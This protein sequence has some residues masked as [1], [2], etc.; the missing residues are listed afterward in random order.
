[1]ALKS[2]TVVILRN[3]PEHGLG[4]A[5]NAIRTWLDGQKIQPVEFR[6]LPGGGALETK[7][8]TEDEAHLFDQTF[9]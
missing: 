9:A 1:M 6:T 7:F 3:D 5:M 4:Y 8:R 2:P